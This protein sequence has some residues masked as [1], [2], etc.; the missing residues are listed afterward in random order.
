MS[1]LLILRSDALLFSLLYPW[2]SPGVSR[3][4]AS[5]WRRALLPFFSFWKDEYGF[6]RCSQAQYCLHSTHNPAAR[7]HLLGMSN[8]RECNTLLGK[9]D[10]C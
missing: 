1:C 6:S 4:P 7:E 10:F 5:F 2:I 3:V 9:E 8:A